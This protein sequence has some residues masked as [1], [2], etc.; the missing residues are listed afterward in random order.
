MCEGDTGQRAE[1]GMLPPPHLP[2]SPTRWSS[3]SGFSHPR[4][5][6][7]KKLEALLS[8]RYVPTYI[9]LSI[10]SWIS[11]TKLQEGRSASAL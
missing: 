11:H 3:S 8:N 1:V 9:Y 2:A 5:Q 10:A 4:A 6:V 7:R